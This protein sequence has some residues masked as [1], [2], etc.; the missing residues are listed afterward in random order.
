MAATLIFTLVILAW[1]PFRME[2]P[3]A[4]E[5]WRGLLN[6]SSFAIRYRRLF[7]VVPLII[8]AIGLDWI[9][10]HYRDEV[11]YLRWPRLAQA[12]CLAVVLLLLFISTGGEGVGE[13]FVYQGF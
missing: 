5:F 12:F 11:I 7:L 9:Q 6:W 3:E 8:G 13:P 2:L 1:V 10:Y 4:V